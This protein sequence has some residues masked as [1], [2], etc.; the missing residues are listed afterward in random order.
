MNK[1][2]AIGFYGI[3]ICI[4]LFLIAGWNEIVI[5]RFGVIF[6]SILLLLSMWV[7]IKRDAYEV[8][9]E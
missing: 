1:E 2:R 7:H 4:P 8:K 5:M 9:D 6:F 3:A